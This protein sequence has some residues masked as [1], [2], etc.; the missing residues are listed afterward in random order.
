MV[1]NSGLCSASPN[2]AYPTAGP[3]AIRPHAPTLICG[4]AVVYD[5]NG[6]TTAYDVD[7]SGPTP[8]R[9]FAYD[10]ENRP[11]SITQNGLVTRFAYG[12]D[13]ARS[14]KATSNTERFFFGGDDLLVQASN[15]S[16]LLTSSIHPDV[17]R[18]VDL[19]LAQPNYGAIDFAF[20]DH[21]ASNRLT[22]RYYPATTT[23]SDYGPYGQPLT[24]NGSTPLN[25]K[26]YINERYDTE[27]NLQYLN[28]RYYDPLLGRFLSPDTW[29]PILAGVD[30]NRYAYAGN[31]PVNFSD[32]NGHA[33][34]NSIGSQLQRLANRAM[35]EFDAQSPKK[36]FTKAQLRAIN[37]QP[38][39]RAMFRGYNIDAMVREMV[40]KDP[41]LNDRLR[42]RSNSGVDFKDKV[43]GIEYEMTTP[44][45]YARKAA[46]YGSHIEFINTKTPLKPGARVLGVFGGI[47]TL[48]GLV[49]VAVATTKNPNM[50]QQE[51]LY[52]ASGL[53]GL[54]RETGVCCPG[55]P[56]FDMFRDGK[57]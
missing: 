15:L 21:K 35:R 53:I 19:S 16:G 17:R 54:A 41:V 52:R 29:D 23:K 24:S 51:F 38:W 12:P 5:A 48:L 34:R 49:D 30:V 46:K 14:L 33:S 37:E 10:L 55:D 11:L 43:T 6:N 3:S 4:V 31:D 18:E 20:K 8:P 22:L 39:R 50:S 26:A 57:I 32:A 27:T 2:M 36:Q 56:I 40:D 1:W 7:G 42:G 45:Q 47:S 28:A 44:G 13:G 9:S 25:G